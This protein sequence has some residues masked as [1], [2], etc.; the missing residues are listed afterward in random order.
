M[1]KSAL[2]RMSALKGRPEMADAWPS[3]RER[4][5]PE[6]ASHD[7]W[8]ICG[9]SLSGAADSWL[10]SLKCRIASTRWHLCRRALDRKG[11]PE[12][13]ACP[14]VHVSALRR[15]QENPTTLY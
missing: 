1:P 3:R 7:H 12:I 13:T 2:V 15:H 8:I 14:S 5:T 6:I 4:A 10:S 11:P 9:A